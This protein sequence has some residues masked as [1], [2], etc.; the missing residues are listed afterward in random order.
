MLASVYLTNFYYVCKYDQNHCHACD[1]Y[2]EFPVMKIGK[3]DGFFGEKHLTE[4]IPDGFYCQGLRTVQHKSL[5]SSVERP[6][7]I[8]SANRLFTTSLFSVPPSMSPNTTYLPSSLIPSAVIIVIP[9]LSNPSTIMI[10]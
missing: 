5:G 9:P 2:K 6:R 4:N 1:F 3:Y 8:K 10:G 7:F